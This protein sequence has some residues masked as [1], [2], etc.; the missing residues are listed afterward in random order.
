MADFI[1][2]YYECWFGFVQGIQNVTQK[3]TAECVKYNVGYYSRN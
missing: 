1:S 3:Y 2:M